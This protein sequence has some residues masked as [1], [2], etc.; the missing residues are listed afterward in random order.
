LI[1]L[2]K[3]HQGNKPILLVGIKRD[4]RENPGD[5]KL[6]SVEEVY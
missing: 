3:L 2:I 4:L 6:V 5:G 1:P